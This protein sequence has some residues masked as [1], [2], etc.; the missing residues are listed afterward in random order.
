MIE[1]LIG[2][3]VALFIVFMLYLLAGGDDPLKES[4][5]REK[6]RKRYAA[7]YEPQEYE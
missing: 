1:F 6:S 4:R 5:E 7:K 3:L 2:M